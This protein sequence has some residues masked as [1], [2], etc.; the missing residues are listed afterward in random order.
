MPHWSGYFVRDHISV[1]IGVCVSM[2]TCIAQFTTC[3][4]RLAK[5]TEKGGGSGGDEVGEGEG[6]WGGGEVAVRGE[7]RKV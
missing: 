2:P 3:P 6:R 1:L 7:T 5:I 4:L